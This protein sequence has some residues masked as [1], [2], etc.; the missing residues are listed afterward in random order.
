MEGSVYMDKAMEKKIDSIFS[1][2]SKG[3]C[4]GGQVAVKKKGKL[5][6]NKNFGYANLEHELPVK[7][8]TVFHVASV[9]K[10]VTVM[11][12]MLLQEEGKLSI[13]DDVRK[14]LPDLI[15]FNEPVTIRDMMNNVSGIRDQWELLMISGVRIDDTITQQ[16]AL[17]M[18]GNQEELNFQPKSRYMYSNSNFTLLVE[19]IERLSGKPLN[20]F[21]IEK[22]FNPLGMNNTIFKDSYWKLIKNRA[23]SYN[24]T[25][26]GEFVVNVLNYGT[27]GATALNT[28]ATDFLKWMDNYREP[29]IC[30]KETLETM[31]KA[32]TLLNGKESG[33]A[34]GLQVGEYKDYKYIEH[35]GAD[36]AYRAQTLRFTEDDIDIVIFSNT[37]NMLMRDAAFSLADIILGCEV[38]DSTEKAPQC[39]VEDYDLVSSEGF[40]FGYTQDLSPLGF[41]IALKGEVPNR[42][43]GYVNAPLIHVSGN[44]FKMKNSNADLYLGKEGGLKIKTNLIPLEKLEGYKRVSESDSRYLGRYESKELGTYYEVVEEDGL[45]YFNHRRNGKN[46]LY[47]ISGD[48]FATG[49][50]M[51]YTIEFVKEADAIKGFKLSG[52]RVRNIRFEKI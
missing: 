47:K 39:F 50:P 25:G 4:P 26:T 45:L 22:I 42:M 34:G 21:A 28:T 48:K 32:P 2:W 30:T 8:D 11:C 49:G 41:T 15:K 51:T 17:T 7:D 18:I 38:E 35:G 24:D 46:T 37:Q 6:Y 12:V 33:Y 23:N 36:A 44:H 14:Y 3:L 13:D 10:Q 43:G 1:F 5:I 16:D 29:T 27:Y 31:F 40:Y 20:E 52:G 9:S 19:I